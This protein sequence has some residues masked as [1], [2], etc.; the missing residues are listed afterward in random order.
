M[1]IR[2]FKLSAT[3]LSYKPGMHRKEQGGLW[4]HDQFSQAGMLRRH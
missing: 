1:D 3:F 2:R 4:F